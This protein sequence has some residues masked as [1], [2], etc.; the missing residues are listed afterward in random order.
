[1]SGDDVL[2]LVVEE[3]SRRTMRPRL[4]DVATVR[5]VER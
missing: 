4:A 5:R 1:M 3:R 2:R